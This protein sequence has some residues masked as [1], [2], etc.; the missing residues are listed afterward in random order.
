VPTL[1]AGKSLADKL[2]SLQGDDTDSLTLTDGSRIAVIG[3]G[4]AG[5]L[6]AYF[7]LRMAEDIGLDVDVDVYEPRRFAH[8][9]PAGC[10][11]CG[12]VVSESLVQILAAEGVN[13]PVEVVQRGIDSYTLHLDA[14]TV[15]IDTPL[16]EKRIAA[17]YRG[18]GPRESEAIG[19]VGFDGYLQ[20]MAGSMG[21]RIVRKLAS[22][23]ERIEGGMR[24][25]CADGDEQDYDLVVVASGVNSHFLD[26][27]EGLEIGYRPPEARKAFICEFELGR[28]TIEQHMG[29]SM[30]V[31]LLDLPGLKFAAIIPKGDLVTMCVLGDRADEDLIDAFVHSPEV[32]NCFPGGQVP[33]PICHCFPRI[34]VRTALKPFA[35]RIVIIGDTGTTRLYKDGIGGAYRTAKAA[36]RTALFQGISEQDFQDHFWPAC[37]RIEFDN[38]IGRVIFFVTKMI[39]KWRFLRRAVFTMTAAEQRSEKGPRRMSNVLWDVFTGSAPYREVLL[40]TLHPGY[41]TKFTL[42]VLASVFSFGRSPRPADKTQKTR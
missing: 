6:F 9:G 32:M 4:P 28:E 2:G 29:T 25:G 31:F 18:N 3:G 5:S 21:A 8:K 39:Q 17:V 33:S 10:N 19:F 24:V 35:D 37:K 36:A 15:R 23:I 41:V 16:A 22:S 11:H 42:H 20:R 14:G 26:N 34:N 7:L 13:I 12:G 40:N 30:H 1:D 38:G 27:I